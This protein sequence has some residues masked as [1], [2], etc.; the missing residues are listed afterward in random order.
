MGAL[1]LIMAALR[2]VHVSEED[3]NTMKKIAVPKGT[4]NATK[5]EST[6]FESMIFLIEIENA[7]NYSGNVVDVDTNIS[8]KL[9]QIK[10]AEIFSLV[11][12]R[13][14]SPMKRI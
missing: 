3:I 14:V 11:M 5:C 13:M 10:F 9:K 8:L 7:F 6:L 2:F 1:I 12:H 4:E